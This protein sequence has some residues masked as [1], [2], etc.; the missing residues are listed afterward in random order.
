MSKVDIWEYVI[1]RKMYGFH[2]MGPKTDS[3]GTHRLSLHRSDEDPILTD[4]YLFDKEVNHLALSHTL[5]IRIETA[6][7]DTVI[8]GVKSC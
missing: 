8:Y 7:K 4:C 6:E 1:C 2:N 5:Q 3:C